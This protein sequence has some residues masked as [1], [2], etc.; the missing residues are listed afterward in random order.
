MSKTIDTSRSKYLIANEQDL[1]WG[2]VITTTGHQEIEPNT[3]YPSTE[4][5][6]PY[7]FSSEKGRTL[8]EYV[9]VYISR[10]KGHFV[11]AHQKKN[12]LWRDI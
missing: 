4:H 5:P 12:K 7:L 6:L 9:L 3:A 11:S 10:G 1:D 2:L 8:N